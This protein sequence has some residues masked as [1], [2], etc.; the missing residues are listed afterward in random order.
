MLQEIIQIALITSRITDLL[1]LCTARGTRIT[2]ALEPFW[3]LLR[4]AR[5]T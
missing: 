2:S 3:A 5:I 1:Q 4:A